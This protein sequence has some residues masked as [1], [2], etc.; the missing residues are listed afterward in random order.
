MWNHAKEVHDERKDL[1]FTMK[2][3][4][5]DKDPL[6]RILRESIKINKAKDE[7]LV[8]LMNSKNE[9]FGLKVVRPKFGVD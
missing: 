7:G 4:S 2:R 5:I 9:Y 6:R 3:S 1:K 8:L